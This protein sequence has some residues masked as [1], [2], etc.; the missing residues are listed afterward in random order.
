MSID[1]IANLL[2]Q[3]KNA[4]MAGRKA[5][6]LPHSNLLEEIARK[7]AAAKFLGEVRVFKAKGK[8]GKCL[9]LDLLYEDDQP[10]VR[11]VKRVSKPGRRIYVGREEV[12]P[13]QSGYGVAII[14][15][16][17]GVLTD[18]EARRRGL[19]GEYLCEVT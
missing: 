1:P 10:R 18:L 11:R 13:V 9:H 19:G 15:T 3:I 4:Q 14:A 8:A 2:T 5:V 7:L 6:E 17:R 12:K 16:S